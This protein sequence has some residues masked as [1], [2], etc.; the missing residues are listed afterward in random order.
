MKRQSH[1]FLNRFEDDEASTIRTDA[2]VERIMK[3]GGCSPSTL[4]LGLLYVERLKQK[5]HHV[6]ITPKNIQRFY[7]VSVM[8][9]AKHW[10]DIYFSNKHWAKIGGVSLAEINLLELEF[11]K[12]MNW[13]LY[14]SFGEYEAFSATI[15]DWQPLQKAVTPIE[16]KPK[17]EMNIPQQCTAI[18]AS[19]IMPVARSQDI[20][21]GC[22][23]HEVHWDRNVRIRVR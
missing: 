4:A 15:L 16:M 21:P 22:S 9:S 3:Y 17:R 8:V 5:L 6:W 1:E 13:E 7:L 23:D 2:Y 12:A 14:V 18:D 20:V 19:R 11:L 10:E